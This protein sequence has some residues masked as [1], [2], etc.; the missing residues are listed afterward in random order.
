MNILFNSEGTPLMLDSTS[1]FGDTLNDGSI[2]EGMRKRDILAPFDVSWMNREFCG[3]HE[4]LRWGRDNL[5]PLRANEIIGSTSVLNTGLKFVRELT[6]G[7]GVYPCHVDGYDEKGNEVLKP[8]K[9]KVVAD[10]LGSR[11]V[12]RYLEKGSRDYFKVGCAAVEMIPDQKGERVVGLN[13]VN[14]LYFR[15]SAPNAYGACQCVVS[16]NWGVAHRHP[17]DEVRVLETLMDYSPEL[18]AEWLKLK[19]RFKHPFV[20]AVRDSWS[21][22]EVYGEPVWLPAYR[23]GWVDV[24]HLV[25]TFLKRAYKNQITWKWHVQIPYSYWDRKYP[26]SKYSD[27]A[28]RKMDIQRDMDK[29][30]QNLCGV[31]NAEKPLFSNYAVNEMNGKI[32]EEWKITALDNKY[33]GGDNLVTSAAANSEI[34]FALMVNPNVLGA[35]MPGGTYA[36]N[37]GGSNIREAFLVN[38]ANAW[39][40]RQ[41]LLDPVKLMLRLNGVD[42]VELRF[43]NTVLTT[44]DS[45]AGTQRTLS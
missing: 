33:H 19:G 35:G 43:R 41:N 17:G 1:F 4:V 37:Q 8:V 36:G 45:G 11:M 44:L 21:N 40:D 9:S 25:P 24:A 22:N 3:G 5:F 10:L 34:L 7:Q 31:E 13:V 12:R 42:D 18:H 29:I 27:I 15:F 14:P 16:P 32:E 28:A 30:E 2:M 20:Y 38:I 23:L 39:I 26:L 6:V